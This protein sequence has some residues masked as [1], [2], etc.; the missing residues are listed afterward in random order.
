[1]TQAEIGA[2]ANVRVPAALRTVLLL[3]ALGRAGAPMTA[4]SLANRLGI[5]RSSTYQLLEV[6]EAEGFV[7]HFP[8]EKRWSLGVAAFE[9]GSAYLRHDPLERLAQPLLNRLLHQVQ[10]LR[11]GG[12]AAVGQVGILDGT[13]LLYL[14]KGQTQA[15]TQANLQVVTD[16]GVRIPAHLTA[17][18]RSMLS[19]LDRAQLRALYPGANDQSLSRR[20]D[21]GPVSIR[22]LNVILAAERAAGFSTEVGTVSSG[23]S[24]VAAAAVNHLKLPVAAFAITFRS[25]RLDAAEQQQIQDQLAPLVGQAARELSKR[26]GVK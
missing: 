21:S 22:D 7:V 9:L 26:L 20:T 16:V 1:M 13:D 15:H 5:P 8:E 19:L 11:P 17:S 24:S 23:Y 3:Q 6:L 12:F 25:D 10:A 18:G 14:L 4:Q 2:T